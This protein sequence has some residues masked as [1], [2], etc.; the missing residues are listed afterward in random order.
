MTTTRLR[1]AFTPDPRAE[2]AVWVIGQRQRFDRAVDTPQG[3]AQWFCAVFDEP[4]RVRDR[5][6]VRVVPAGALHLIPPRTPIA[7]GARDG[8][9]RSWVRFAGR[10]V[11]RVRRRCRLPVDRA[12]VV[13]DPALHQPWLAALHRECAQARPA[14]RILENLFECWWLAVVR[15]SGGAI[16]GPAP[17]ALARDLRHHLES[18]FA[19]DWSLETLAAHFATSRVRLC[20]H[21]CAA[22][23]DSPM[24]YQRRLRLT[25]AEDL[26]HGTDLAVGAIAQRCGFR[27]I[28]YFS[29]VF[30]AHAGSAPSVW[31]RRMRRGVIGA[32]P[33]AQRS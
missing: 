5:D 21:F 19:E 28:Y 24:A 16:A 17:S 18:R 33:S 20:R 1:A 6:G 9:L 10:G 2:L 27:D 32:A 26:L 14:V 22:Y 30:R 3:M 25:L 15:A 31:R 4:T 23:G 13:D 11:E 12:V 8:C 29:R 7:H